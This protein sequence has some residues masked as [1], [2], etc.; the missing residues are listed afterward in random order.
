MDA[1]R[2]DGTSE[3]QSKGM[4]DSHVTS[5]APSRLTFGD[6]SGVKKRTRVTEYGT[7]N[8][9][10]RRR[11]SSVLVVTWTA[12]PAEAQWVAAPYLPIN[13][14]GDV[15]AGMG[16]I[17]GSIGYV[18]SR[19]GF[20]FDLARYHHFFRDV[21]VSNLVSD[22]RIDLDTDAWSVMGN[23]VM[24]IHFQGAT[25][26]RPYGTAVFGVMRAMFDFAQGGTRSGDP[27]SPIIPNDIHQNNLG[28]NAGAGVRYLLND[29]VGFRGDL[30]YFRA[31]VDE[32]AREGG[33]FKDCGFWRAAFGVTFEFGR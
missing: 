28:F 27:S 3:P 24:P 10:S 16:G 1:R 31:L 18:G 2:D 33:Y 15:E 22:S 4:N 8:A 20:E 12:V 11:S 25:N 17:G 9:N 26:W 32:D 13:I 6:R 7:N 30:R 29:R 19:V 5:E 23:V 14:A 21:D